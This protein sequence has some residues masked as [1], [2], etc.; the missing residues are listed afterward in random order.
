MVLSAQIAAGQTPDQSVNDG[1]AQ[2][3]TKRLDLRLR[4]ISALYT[5]E[6]I[7]RLLAEMERRAAREVVVEGTREPAPHVT[8]DVWRAI[9]AP[10]WALLHPTQAWRIV[11]PLPP[12]QTQGVDEK[13]YSSDTDGVPVDLPFR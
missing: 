7:E 11:L 4:D 13:P 10:L 5:P 2:E 8:P 9:A 3:K 1:S 6:Q 12:D